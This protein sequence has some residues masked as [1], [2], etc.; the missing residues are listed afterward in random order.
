METAAAAPSPTLPEGGSIRL[1]F[2]WTNPGGHF[3]IRDAEGKETALVRTE[4]EAPPA[5]APALAQARLTLDLTAIE[6]VE[7]DF[8]L[9]IWRVQTDR[10]PR[11]F[12]TQEDEGTTTLEDGTVL[13]RDLGGDVYR[14]PHPA[15]LDPK[16]A[17]L[18]WAHSE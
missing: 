7:S 9:R 11:S 8:Q 6:A 14:V 2:P 12:V 16:S 3:S 1:C 13:I 4:A 18:L 5:L 10:G 17:K 15:R